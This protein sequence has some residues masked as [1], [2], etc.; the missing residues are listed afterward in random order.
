MI[1]KTKSINITLSDILE[2]D[3]RVTLVFENCEFCEFAPTDFKQ[4]ELTGEKHEDKFWVSE[5]HF[6]I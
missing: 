4:F 3:E 6:C 1:E 5:V 2:I